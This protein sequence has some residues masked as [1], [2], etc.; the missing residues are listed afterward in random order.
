M[1]ISYTCSL[2]LVEAF[3]SRVHCSSFMIVHID[4]KKKK[5]KKKTDARLGNGQLVR[6][7]CVIENQFDLSRCIIGHV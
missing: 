6:R 3:M 7:W 1:L 2:H 4:L 5:K